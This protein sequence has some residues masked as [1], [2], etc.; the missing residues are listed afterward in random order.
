MVS[1]ASGAV[2]D[3]DSAPA[4]PPAS[5]S[6]AVSDT[7]VACDRFSLMRLGIS[8]CLSRETALGSAR[9][10]GTKRDIRQEVVCKKKSSRRAD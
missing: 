5:K 1:L 4:T 2:A 8:D 10:P 3:L 7:L 9:K 6:F